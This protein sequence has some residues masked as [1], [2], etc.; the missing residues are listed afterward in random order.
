METVRTLH[1]K[2]AHFKIIGW[3]IAIDRQGR[4]VLIDLN[5]PPGQNQHSCGP[6]FGD[7]TERVLEDVFLTKSLKDGK[8]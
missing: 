5:T 1:V 6:T 3:D 7:L 4:P 8:N 2:M